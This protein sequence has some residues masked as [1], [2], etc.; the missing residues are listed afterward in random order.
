MASGFFADVP[1]L[2]LVCGGVRTSGH[3]AI[4]LWTFTG[5]HAATKNRLNV[6]GWEEWDLD[7]SGLIT[8]S[9]G[10]FDAESYARQT[11]PTLAS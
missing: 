4:Y 9:R 1:D 8:L 7:A 6:V 3:H 2:A 11:A 10:W 5:T